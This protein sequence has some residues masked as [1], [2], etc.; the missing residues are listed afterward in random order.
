[1]KA[2]EGSR[3]RRE[4]E[5]RWQGGARIS[6][7]SKETREAKAQ[8]R[9]GDA[10]STGRKPVG[11]LEPLATLKQEYQFNE[12]LQNSIR[13][14]TRTYA[15]WRRIRGD[16]N[17]YW[18]SLGYA[19]FE[20]ALSAHASGN[21]QPA[22]EL[23]RTI[24]TAPPFMGAA[25]RVRDAED[26]RSLVSRRLRRVSTRTH[27]SWGHKGALGPDARKEKCPSLFQ[28]II[29]EANLDAA[30]VTTLRHIVGVWIRAN[31]DKMTMPGD[32][33]GMSWSTVALAL[34]YSDLDAYCQDVVESS[35]TD[36]SDLVMAALPQA[37]GCRTRNVYLD[38]RE[39]VRLKF[40]DFPDDGHERGRIH[41]LL[42]PGHYDLLYPL[43]DYDDS[44]GE[45][46][47]AKGRVINSPKSWEQEK[48]IAEQRR[49][50]RASS[51]SLSTDSLHLGSPTNNNSA[52]LD[53]LKKKGMTAMSSPRL[54]NR[55][56]KL[57]LD[58]SGLGVDPLPSVNS[59]A[60]MR[61]MDAI[62][63]DLGSDPFGVKPGES[64]MEK[65]AGL[66][67]RERN[68]PSR[69]DLSL[70]SDGVDPLPSVKSKAVLDT[71]IMTS[72]NE[73][74]NE[75][76]PQGSCSSLDEDIGAELVDD[77]SSSDSDSDLD[78][79]SHDNFGSKQPN[80]ETMKINS[81]F[82]ALDYLDQLST[83][84]VH[85]NDGDDDIS[86]DSDHSHGSDSSGVG[87]I[88]PRHQHRP[89]PLFGAEDDHVDPLPSV[90]SRRD[91]TSF[92]DSYELHPFGISNARPSDR[93]KGSVSSN[94]PAA[95]SSKTAARP[96]PVPPIKPGNL[97]KRSSFTM[98][99]G[100]IVKSA[101]NGSREDAESRIAK[102]KEALLS[103]TE[104]REKL[105][106]LLHQQLKVT[107]EEHEVIEL[108]KATIHSLTL[109]LE[110]AKTT[111]GKSQSKCV[112]LEKVAEDAHKE[113]QQT[114]EE[115]EHEFDQKKA[116]VEAKLQLVED[117]NKHL[118]MEL[119]MK[120]QSAQQH[121]L[122]KSALSR[123]QDENQR[124]LS[125]PNRNEE[126]QKREA[127]LKSSLRE[128]QIVVDQLINQVGVWEVKYS[129]S[130]REAEKAK[131]DNEELAQQHD[132]DY[133]EICRELNT[134]RQQYDEVYQ[135][136]L[137]ESREN[138][139]KVSDRERKFCPL[140]PTRP[141]PTTILQFYT[142]FLIV[143]NRLAFY[144]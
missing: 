47:G 28:S 86:N 84:G 108:Q 55:P 3:S 75:V 107:R 92:A 15:H 20:R 29:Q 30:I 58:R 25:D 16:G 41:V 80:S 116:A 139:V 94:T 95:P 61:P 67:P 14:M 7:E 18:R 141:P 77:S 27:G 90:R 99:G 81:E 87:L 38:R 113:A 56:P 51:G 88:T 97:S 122:L 73:T 134:V 126:Y 106:K 13:E 50:R 40:H 72:D 44:G 64:V 69:L 52:S 83:A 10:E 42:K 19:L 105:A 78:D 101:E 104:E 22:M 91:L 131:H 39:G 103:K 82:N 24:D 43:V 12:H 71:K 62:V 34:G 114:I 63:T 45:T 5:A 128:A 98:K 89:P 123:L 60:N 143:C 23:Q 17:C 119:K 32:T 9:G 144:L 70:H 79:F 132:R 8:E 2:S 130:L 120:E 142:G 85:D 112:A 48:F 35:G 102:L 100:T 74:V 37:L 110:T 33:D 96:P 127:D 117:E 76:D 31:G 135:S 65:S 4:R 124:L 136:F 21:M 46:R 49:Q 129:N 36:A 53:Y 11:P 138:T 137:N 125:K 133:E 1:M 54:M 6:G 115:A 93:S 109:E 121:E 118:R 57:S 140:P 26:A 66:T 59:K 111:A 68:R